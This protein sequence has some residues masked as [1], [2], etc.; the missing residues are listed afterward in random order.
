MAEIEYLTYPPFEKQFKW[1]GKDNLPIPQ[2]GDTVNVTMNDLGLGVVRGYVLS[3]GDP[4]NQYLGVVVFLSAPPQWFLDQNGGE[5]KLCVVY[6]AEI[7]R[8][9]THSYTA[10]YARDMSIITVIAAN[11]EQA[12]S[13]ITEQLRRVENPSRYAYYR[14]WVEDGKQIR[15]N[16]DKS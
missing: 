16:P 6:G 11:R 2:V 10:M 7:G 12:E 1:S 3:A 8:A 4:G 5:N 9:P 14:Q 13:K 15:E